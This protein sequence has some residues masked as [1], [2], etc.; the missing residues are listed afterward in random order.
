VAG[1]LGYGIPAAAFQAG[2]DRRPDPRIVASPP[3]RAGDIGC[4]FGPVLI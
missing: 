2:I 3:Y 4:I 1:Q